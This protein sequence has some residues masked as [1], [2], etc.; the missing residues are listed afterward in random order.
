MGLNEAQVCASVICVTI[1]VLIAI[2]LFALSWSVLDPL[3]IGLDINT[4]TKT[5]DNSTVYTGGRYLLGLG[6]SFVKYPKKLI[7]IDF[8]PDDDCDTCGD[9]ALNAGTK[10]G[11]TITVEVTLYYKLNSTELGSL[12]S[13]F[14]QDYAPKFVRIA[15]STLKNT[16]VKFTALEYFSSRKLIAEQMLNDLQAA[17]RDVFAEVELLQ[18]R[19]ISLSTSFE[20]QLTQNVIAV[21]DQVK[22]ELMKQV[23][24]IQANTQVILAKA[25]ANITN[26]LGQANADANLI[27]E[28]AR[29]EG[30]KLI[31]N[32]ERDAYIALKGDLGLDNAQLFQYL[33]ATRKLRLA[34]SGDTLLVGIGDKV[35]INLQGLTSQ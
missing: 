31:V 1:L 34:A 27:N 29:A 15:Q 10:D 11:Q 12:Y 28:K 16:C 7:I 21:Q 5:V 33:W 14:G 26:I 20:D 19:G 6:H 32:I 2:L 23:S 22:A 30:T 17:F 8:S 13:T 24:I 4:I 9:V 25:Q 3:E 35:N 18:L